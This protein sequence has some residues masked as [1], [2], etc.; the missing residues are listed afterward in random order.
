MNSINDFNRAVTFL[1]NR[2]ERVL[3]L[4]TSTRWEGSE[5]DAKSTQLAIRMKEELGDLAT[6][7]HVPDLHIYQCE[8][9]V[10]TEKEIHVELKLQ[11]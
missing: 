6:L 4:T 11:Y 2:G 5:E 7:M 1:K 10:S 8:G 3:L 9:N